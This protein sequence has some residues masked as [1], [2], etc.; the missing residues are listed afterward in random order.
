MA[1]KNPAAADRWWEPAT[2]AVPVVENRNPMHARFAWRRVLVRFWIMACMVMT[3]LLAFAVV[4]LVAR[5]LS[6][7]GTTAPPV[8][9]SQSSQATAAAQL[10]LERWLRTDP[11]P[12]PSGRV[13]QFVGSTST[14]PPAPQRGEEPSDTTLTTYT[15]SVADKSSNLYDAALQM[16]VSPTQGQRMIASPALLPVPPPSRGTGGGDAQPWPG[17]ES[18]SKEQAYA[19]AVTAW[20]TAYTSGDPDQLKQVV[21]DPDPA[22]SY[23]PLSGVSFSSPQ[24][25]AVGN[26]WGADQ[27]RNEQGTHPARVLV[28]AQAQQLPAGQPPA[29]S[30]T[31]GGAG[32]VTYDLLLDRANTATPVVVAWGAPGQ[33][34]QP[35][36]N[37]LTGRVLTAAT[38]PA[39]SPS[40][41][42]STSPSA[43]RTPR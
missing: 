35:Y 16:A 29:S 36:S 40:P 24:I 25:V 43:S 28:R 5:V 1:R 19:V 15:F 8:G 22:R 14:P 20:A 3:P 27:D 38:P 21:A 12:I 30:D 18:G 9:Q 17:V 32:T 26:L 39:A 37:A 7:P 6:G 31:T 13:L 23:L 41:G 4:V 2:V 34:L 11:A 33:P 42:T 10:E